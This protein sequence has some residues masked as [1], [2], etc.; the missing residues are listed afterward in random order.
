MVRDAETRSTKYDK[1]LDGD[2][3]NLRITAY[4]PTMVEQVHARYAEQFYYEGKVKH[5]MNAQGFFG[6]EQ[7]HYMNFAYELWARTRMFEDLTL[8]REAELIADK[9]MRRGLDAA[10]LVAIAQLFGVDL[11]SWP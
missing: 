8:R 1:K 10:H 5:Y 7:H 4:K 6:V 9:W 3:W 2:I 11:T